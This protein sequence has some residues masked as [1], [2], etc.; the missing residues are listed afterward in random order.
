MSQTFLKF[1]TP[2]LRRLLTVL[3]LLLFL[4]STFL[5]IQCF[6]LQLEPPPNDILVLGHLAATRRT[7]KV[8]SAKQDST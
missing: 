4:D 5:D 3:L 6:A 2:N 1:I 8:S 7:E